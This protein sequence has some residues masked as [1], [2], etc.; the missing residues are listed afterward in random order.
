M[1]SRAEP[2]E[3]AAWAFVD[4]AFVRASDARVPALDRGLLL[5]H[6][7]FATMRGYAGRCFRA[8][9]HLAQLARG[10]ARFGIPMPLSEERLAAIADAC[11]AKTAARDA[12]VRVTLTAGPPGGPPTLFVLARAWDELPSPADYANGVATATVATRR[13][14]PA[15]VDPSI[16]T[17]SYGPQ[18]LARREAEALGV[19]EGLMLA[20]D[21]SIAC[22]TMATIFVV[23]GARLVTPPLSTGCRDG[24]TR[25]ALLDLAPSVGLRPVEAPIA[26][27]ALGEVDEA[28][29][30]STRVEC[31][32]IARADGA[33]IGRGTFERTRALHAALRR[34]V[35]EETA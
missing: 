18:V 35:A 2:Q 21:G 24:I 33:P 6:G 3:R 1:S 9:A 32:P 26:P 25:R 19:A 4:G 22:G 29:F 13:A 16:K 11:A 8:R 28:F 5:G 30:A 34:V 12:Y 15:C 10:A 31:L 20:L 23:D 27:D 17:T 7:V 14:P